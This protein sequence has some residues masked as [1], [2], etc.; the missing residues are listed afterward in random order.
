M[1]LLE[2]IKA[3]FQI[4]RV[5]IQKLTKIAYAIGGVLCFLIGF[6]YSLGE[7]SFIRRVVILTLSVVIFIVFSKF[8][9]YLITFILGVPYTIISKIRQVNTSN[10]EFLK[11]AFDRL[12][13]L[14]AEKCIDRAHYYETLDILVDLENQE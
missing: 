7:P 12:D 10:K 9:T 5:P 8:I 14:Y 6:K 1:E 3:D 13:Y 2:Q 11:Y 4:D